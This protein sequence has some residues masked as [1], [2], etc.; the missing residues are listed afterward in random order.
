MNTVDKY[1]KIVEWS[2]VDNC[3]IGSCP[4]LFMGGCHGHDRQKVFRELCQ[5]VDETLQLYRVQGK[6][7]PEPWSGHEFV[8]VMHAVA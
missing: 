4:E 8:N 7:L 1:V 3:Y 6:A 2:D 5:I